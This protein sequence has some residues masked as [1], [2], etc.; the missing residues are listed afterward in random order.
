MVL[1]LC[2]TGRRAVLQ[3]YIR[4]DA[5][6]P[7]YAYLFANHR[8]EENPALGVP[9]GAELEFGKPK[10]RCALARC[11]ADLLQVYGKYGVSDPTS[12]LGK[13]S[14]LMM[15]AWIN[16]ANFLDP[17]GDGGM[18]VYQTRL[19]DPLTPVHMNST[20]LAQIRRRPPDVTNRLD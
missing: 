1:T 9:H 4:R 2:K 18:L 13:I 8:P 12:E 20:S 3:E 11:T 17:N 19:F 5:S 10:S 14:I 7:A 15:N 6:Y 16:F